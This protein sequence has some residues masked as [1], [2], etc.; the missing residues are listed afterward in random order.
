MLPA[1]AHRKCPSLHLGD[2]AGRD[3]AAGMESVWL[4]SCRNLAIAAYFLAQLG[5]KDETYDEYPPLGIEEWHKKQ[6]VYIKAGA[7][8]KK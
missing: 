8:P 2:R 3:P 1:G 6:H 4:Q 7:Q 5:P